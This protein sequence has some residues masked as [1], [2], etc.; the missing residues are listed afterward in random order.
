MSEPKAT[1]AKERAGTGSSNGSLSS[2]Q[3]GHASRYEPLSPL[4][5]VSPRTGDLTPT[6]PI[7]AQTS[8]GTDAP[9][10][11]RPF[12][13]LR[14]QLTTVYGL[15]LLLIIF[16]ICMLLST[17]IQAVYIFLIAFIITIAGIVANFVFTTILLRPL[18]RVTDA[19]QA[20][21]I[22]DLQQRE[23]LPLRL[24]PQDEIDRLAGSLNEMVTRLER[25]EEMQ[26]AAEARFRRFFSDASHQ[27]RT[28]L[29][30]IRGFTE[31]L[32][33]GAKDN[34]E[35]A[36]QVLQRMKN[37]SERMTLLINDL[38]TLARL[39]EGQPLKAQY[40]DLVALASEGIEQTKRRL[41]DGRA[42]KLEK[43]T[44]QGLGLQADKDRIK[45]LIF[46]LLDN[47]VKYGRPAPDGFITLRLNRQGEDAILSVI[48]NGE[49]IAE[50]DL[51]HIF[52]S[53]YRG[54]YRRSSSKISVI[55]TGLGLSIASAIVRAHDGSIT[56][57][58]E[59][60][61]GTEFI[62]RLPCVG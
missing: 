2:T 26:H 61:T 59:P 27:L 58:S 18:W 19:A 53:F 54:Q 47:A 52:E 46:I 51:A 32:M 13:S 34:P 45:Q 39:D 20:I 44:E 6:G 40:L 49:G 10:W 56:V 50:E 25:A 11:L 30:S 62:V 17:H 28:P 4:R 48:D 33:R 22:G 57:Q 16:I 55:G 3:D 38:L 23:R 5:A 37:E 21:A 42:I 9:S 1:D 31:V 35:V 7:F 43:A 24:P 14:I 36:Q 12:F 41:E 29:T 60:G 8:A 15:T